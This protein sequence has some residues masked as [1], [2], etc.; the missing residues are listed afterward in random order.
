MVPGWET[1]GLQDEP[2]DY[3]SSSPLADWVDFS[4]VKE[5]SLDPCNLSHHKLHVGSLSVFAIICNGP[6]LQVSTGK[7]KIHGIFSL[8]WIA[9]CYILMLLQLNYTPLANIHRRYRQVPIVAPT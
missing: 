8:H 7:R 2:L 5:V 9:F 1:A 4:M 6:T 3:T